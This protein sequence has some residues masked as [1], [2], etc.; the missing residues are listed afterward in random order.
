MD[1]E[2]P[3]SPILPPVA[4]DAAELSGGY[5]KQALLRAFDDSA[6]EWLLSCIYNSPVSANTPAY[7]YL[8]GNLSRLRDILVGKF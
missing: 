2:N 7:N 3:E 1:G 4:S 8:V 5:D 6:R